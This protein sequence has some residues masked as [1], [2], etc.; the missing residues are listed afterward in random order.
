MINGIRATEIIPG[1]CEVIDEEQD[2][3][4]II[5]AANTPESLSRLLDSI[6]ETSPRKIFLV[7]GCEGGKDKQIRP[8]MGE[9]AHYKVPNSPYL[10]S[11][12]WSW[13]RGSP[14][15]EVAY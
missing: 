2:F 5:D 3:G 15:F 9:I 11:P 4:V 6:R 13:N 8:F 12:I 14:C 10:C 1:R 7:F